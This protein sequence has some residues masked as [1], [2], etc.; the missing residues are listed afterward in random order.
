MMTP[1]TNRSATECKSRTHRAYTE[2]VEGLRIQA[3]LIERDAHR[4]DSSAPVYAQIQLLETIADR[5]RFAQE[6]Y[7]DAQEAVDAHIS[8]GCANLAALD[9]APAR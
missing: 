7:D 5:V 1:D 8:R 6:N 3:M 4:F 9:A 2:A